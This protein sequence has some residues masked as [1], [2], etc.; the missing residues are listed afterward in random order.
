M[1]TELNSDIIEVCVYRHGARITR[2][3][4]LETLEQSAQDF[5]MTRLPLCLEDDS[6]IL[7]LKEGN[8]SLN[9]SRLS[10]ALNETN[11]DSQLSLQQQ[12]EELKMQLSEL[13]QDRESCTQKIDKIQ[14]LSY[15]RRHKIKACTLQDISKS[16]L[17]LLDF[18][19]S[20]SKQLKV[21]RRILDE[22]LKSLKN[23]I[24]QLEEK[25]ERGKEMVFYKNLSF[26]GKDLSPQASIRFSYTIPGATWS[27]GYTMKMENYKNARLHM[28][29]IISQNSGEDWQNVTIK[30]C[31]GHLKSHKKMPEFK[32]LHIGRYQD[33][34]ARSKWRPAPADTASLFDDFDRDF[35]IKKIKAPYTKPVPKQVTNNPAQLIILSECQRGHCLQLVECPVQLG[36]SS[37][38]DLSLK[39]NTVTDQHAEITYQQGSYFVRDLNSQNGTRINGSEPIKGRHILN[40]GDILQLG[41]IELLYDDNSESIVSMATQTSISLEDNLSM[42][43]K[44]P[45]ASAATLKRKSASKTKRCAAAPVAGS[46]AFATGSMVPDAPA[47]SPQQIV[48]EYPAE[49]LFNYNQVSLKN[50]GRLRGTLTA[51]ERKEYYM[52][53]FEER[54][55]SIEVI[56]NVI[57]TSQKQSATFKAKPQHYHEIEETHFDSLFEGCTPV[58]IPSGPEWTS[59]SLFDQECPL[60]LLYILT[61]HE[62][63]QVFRTVKMTNTL[64][65]PLLKGPLDVYLNSH[66]LMTG[67]MKL[68]PSQDSFELCLGVEQG[69]KVKRLCNFDETHAGLIG[70]SSKL[71]HKINNTV[72]NTLHQ[73]IDIEIRERLPMPGKDEKIKVHLDEVSPQWSPLQ[74]DG[75]KQEGLHKWQAEVEPGGKQEFHFHYSITLPGKDELQGGNRR[76]Y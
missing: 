72:Q 26:T 30:L 41:G 73:K 28:R 55:F 52:Q 5:T 6:I 1:S 35:S 36:R 59:V 10:I 17:L 44:S 68:C 42:G 65:Q 61:G 23:D 11:D 27:P 37:M 34:A 75:H 14:N 24:A 63:T 8:G 54:N 2:Q 7:T 31:T 38:C 3:C 53:Y 60:E 67:S 21:E 49:D 64:K 13:N 9:N 58:N 15:N 29:A 16:R 25:I 56:E 66:Y 51:I 45:K 32:S 46:M 43:N 33:D 62:S 69:I 18:K 4:K 50:T 19:K 57:S 74:I 22:K 40:N 47:P 48:R 20:T 76:E 12:Y 71:V 70:H 39:D